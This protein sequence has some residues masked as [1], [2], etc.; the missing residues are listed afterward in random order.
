MN[1]K[2][3]IITADPNSI[4]SEIIYKTWK[5][6]NNKERKE[7]FLIG[8]YNLI[9]EQFKKLKIKV[10]IFKVKSLEEAKFSKSLKILDI[11]LVFKNPFFVSQKA[12]SNYLINCLKLADKLAKNNQV[13]GIINCPIDKKLLKDTKKIGVTEYFASICRIFDKT[14]VMMIYNEKLAVVPLTTHIAVKDI[15]KNISKNLIISKVLSLNKNYKKI[16]QKEPKIGILGLNPH[17]GEMEINTEEVKKIIPAI[18]MLKKKGVNVTGP[19][20]NDT[21]FIETYKKFNILVGMYHDQVLTP[22]K[23][24]FHY[25]AINI[26]LGLPYIRVSPD[27]GP[28]YNLIGK[29]KGNY[30]S[31]FH[32]VKFIYNLKK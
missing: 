27:H 5:K 20:V 14:E 31:L 7:I 9:K 30:L 15:S 32:C 2:I 16:F 8:N 6:I 17:N 4:N 18:S 24:L 29:N 10:K 22:F 1:K 25:N 19:L 26:T 12:A 23:T 28:A 21:V 13:K 3:L 11:P